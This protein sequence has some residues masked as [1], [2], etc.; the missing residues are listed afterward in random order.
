[1]G[2][3]LLSENGIANVFVGMKELW[4]MSLRKGMKE[5]CKEK[6]GGSRKWKSLMWSSLI[7]VQNK[8][9]EKG[10]VRTE[11]TETHQRSMVC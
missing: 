1:M 4:W 6:K 3:P 7:K 2:T 8:G 9:I 5:L 11:N 10:S